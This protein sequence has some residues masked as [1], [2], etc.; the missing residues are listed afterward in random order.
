MLRD[1]KW[2][3]A[4]ITSHIVVTQKFI[5]LEKGNIKKYEKK[6]LKASENYQ[7]W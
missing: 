2:E 1:E 6:I 5:Y 3:R 7:P 4:I